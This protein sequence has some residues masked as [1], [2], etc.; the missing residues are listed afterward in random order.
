MISWLW[1]ILAVMAGAFVGVLLM[2]LC[3]ASD[4]TNQKKWWE[5]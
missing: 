3:C 4:S 2:G 1:L 5:E